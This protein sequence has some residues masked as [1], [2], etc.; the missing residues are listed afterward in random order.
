MA[1]TPKFNYLAKNFDEYRNVLKQFAK[2]YYPNSFKDFSDA[3]TNMAFID[4]PAVVGDILS[5]YLDT[6]TSET[7]L[8][9]VQE[10]SNAINLAYNNRYFPKLNTPAVT[11]MDV[12]QLLPSIGTG[13]SVAPDWSYA[14]YVQPNAKIISSE[15]GTPFL[16]ASPINFAYSSSVDP[17]VV[18]VYSVDGDGNAEYYLIKKKA[19]AIAAEIKTVSFNF[20]SSATPYSRLVIADDN[21][22]SVLSAVDGDGNTW[23]EVPYLAQDTVLTHNDNIAALYPSYA[24]FANETPYIAEL[25]SSPKRF[26]TRIDADN[27]IN[28]QFG[29]GNASLISE[30]IIPNLDNVSMPWIGGRHLLDIN[31][32]PTNFLNTNTYGEVP[33]NTSF[34]VSY[35]VGGGLQSNVASR[36][37]TQIGYVDINQTNLPAGPL[38]NQIINSLAFINPNPAAGGR[39]PETIEE[40]AQNAMAAKSSQGRAVTATDYMQI[41]TSMPSKFGS[42]AKAYAVNDNMIQ[43]FNDPNIARTLNVDLYVLGYDINNALAH[44]NVAVKNNLKT[45]LSQY[46]ML[47][48]LVN[49]KDAFII[50]IGVEFEVIAAA[51][52]NTND[53]LINCI[54]A[55]QEVINNKTQQINQPI[56]IGTL[57][58]ALMKV[59]NVQHV[60]SI[61][62][63]NKW[64]TSDGYSGIMYDIKSATRKGIIFPSADP[65]IFEIKYPAADIIGR[66]TTY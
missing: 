32:N 33:T 66:I 61:N 55:I 49:I 52:S 48:D 22:I 51:N 63:T 54:T 25:I 50:N 65:S 15:N 2:T 4:I 53:V 7:N 12:F 20:D 34:T 17:T 10:K 58:N 26:I 46:R 18:T 43:P 41:A 42:V 47:T 11:D 14:L 37:I 45:Y 57:F 29:A 36:T 60:V 38:R 35:L 23:Y 9:T 16:I 13:A 3:S 44:C 19:L 1:T 28:I 40:I 8:A 27:N 21:L 39:A 59:P 62:I 64:R 56:V 30:E 31:Y 24:A 5:F 6:Q